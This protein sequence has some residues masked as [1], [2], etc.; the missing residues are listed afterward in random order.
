M[1]KLV[2]DLYM[3]LA[4]ACLLSDSIHSWSSHPMLCT[5]DRSFQ[6]GVIL[7]YGAAA[8]RGSRR[9]NCAKVPHISSDV[10]LKLRSTC[11]NTFQVN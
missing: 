5:A 6:G 1:C 11:S 9:G 3:Q 10:T 2:R 4:K 8:P 7:T